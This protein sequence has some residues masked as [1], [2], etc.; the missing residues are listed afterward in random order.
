VN[1]TLDIKDS[2]F[3]PKEASYVKFEYGTDPNNMYEYSSYY[4]NRYMN[5]TDSNIDL[6]I[7]N[8]NA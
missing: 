5:L 7:S 1:I 6:T 2:N 4:M 3:H 8:V